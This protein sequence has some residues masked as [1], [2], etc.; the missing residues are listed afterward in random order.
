MA[1]Q[2]ENNNQAKG[3]SGLDSM[4]SDVSKDVE[5]AKRVSQDTQSRSESSESTSRQPSDTSSAQSPQG[6]VG[7]RD[8]P[9]SSGSSGP[10][11]VLGIAAFI[12]VVWLIGNSAKQD[13]PRYDPPPVSTPAPAMIPSL[14]PAPAPAS[15]ASARP[16]GGISEMPPVGEGHVLNREQIRYCFSEDIRLDAMKTLINSYSNVEVDRFNAMVADYN[17]RCARFKYRRGTLES[18]RSEVGSNR[19]LLEGEGR[20][21]V[22]QWRASPK[23]QQRRATPGAVLSP[24]KKRGGQ[25]T[26][27]DT[28]ETGA[29]QQLAGPEKGN[30][31]TAPRTLDLSGLNSAERSSIESACSSDR[32]L[33]GPAAYNQCLSSQLSRLEQGPRNIDLSGL[34]SVER[35]SIE[36][37]CFSDRVLRG[38]AA[39]NQCLSTQLAKL[40]P[41]R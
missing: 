7:T 37:A 34:S 10:K 32:V 35:S 40:R 1:Q 4:V 16:G 26:R 9:V 33:R 15:P 25:T 11:W 5:H 17:S 39:Y 8:A 31:E 6:G 36:S 20:K 21:I 14:A 24:A 22:E 30:R 13:T 29:K 12:F 18:V 41:Y 3:F 19:T 2:P 23:A 38:P 28:N 27:S